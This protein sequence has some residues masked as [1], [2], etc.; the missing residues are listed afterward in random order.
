MNDSKRNTNRGRTGPRPEETLPANARRWAKLDF[1]PAAKKTSRVWPLAALVLLALMGNALVAQDKVPRVR[2][3]DNAPPKTEEVPIT[4][5]GKK[6]PGPKTAPKT[7]TPTPEAKNGGPKTE[8]AKEAQETYEPFEYDKNHFNIDPLFKKGLAE[9]FQWRV[10][11]WTSFNYFNNTDLRELNENSETDIEETDDRMNFFLSGVEVDTFLPINPRLDFRLDVW[12]TGFWGHDQLAGRDNNNDPRDTFSGSNTVNF[13]YLYMNVHFLK[14]PKPDRKIDLIVG[15]QPFQIGGQVT[16]DF[17]QRDTLDA[18]VVSA[19]YKPFGKLDLLVLDVYSSG[20]S[21]SDTYFVTY[22]SH[23]NEKVNGFDGD[24][25]TYRSG[26]VYT[27]PVI[28]DSE[29]GGTFLEGRVF[30]Y[31]AQWGAGDEGGSDRSNLGTGGNFADNDYSIMRGARISGGFRDYIKVSATWAESF[32]IDRKR[33]ANIVYNQDVDNNGKAFDV[34]AKAQYDL[35]KLIKFPLKPAIYGSYFRAS[36]GKYYL[37]G[38]Q[39]SHGF[40]SF[41][42]DRMGGIIH[43]LN[44]G[45]H[46][47]AYVDDDGVDDWTY[48]RR[49]RTGTEVTRAGLRFT[50]WKQLTLRGDVW[51]MNDTNSSDLLGGQQSTTSQNL[52]IIVAQPVYQEQTTVLSAQRRFGAPLGRE[53]NLGLDWQIYKNWETWVTVGWFDPGRYYATPG[54]VQGTPQ[55]PTRAIGFQLGTSFYF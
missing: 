19:A 21:T 23:D 8:P 10:K 4:I 39:Y 6:A 49:R 55:G 7:G 27:Y 44:Y 3:G 13:G 34:E 47:S 36:G 43:N 26:F 31:L 2:E 35:E 1:E 18:V 5:E 46:P 50:L 52:A 45:N 30:Y 15:R 33:P 37:D 32:G 41:K 54:L 24:V 28:G 29:V 16:E 17:F 51:W 14:N 9:R 20:S 12:K 25:N 40:V 11:F 38:T 48:E 22:I 42:G 53:V